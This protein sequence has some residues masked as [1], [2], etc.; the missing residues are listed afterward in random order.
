MIAYN[1]NFNAS[2]L[3]KYQENTKQNRHLYELL[4]VESLKI[5]NEKIKILTL[6]SY[7]WN[8]GTHYYKPFDHKIFN[9]DKFIYEAQHPEPNILVV[10]E[11][12]S[13]NQGWTEG[14]LE[15]VENIKIDI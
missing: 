1:D 6:Q 10:G 8:I 13:R 15:S 12:V 9:Y 14:A 11:C 3:M 5:S 2:L 7:H 4:L